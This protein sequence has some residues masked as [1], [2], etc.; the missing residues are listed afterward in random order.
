M[1]EPEQEQPGPGET[2]SRL[3]HTMVGTFASE[4]RK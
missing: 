2:Y 1:V 4:G 3:E